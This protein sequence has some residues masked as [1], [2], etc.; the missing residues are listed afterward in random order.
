VTLN[1]LVTGATGNI[2]TW[3]APALSSMADIA[4]RGFVRDAAK[5]QPLVDAGVEVAVGDFGDADSLRRA[6]SGIDTVILIAPPGPRC[7]DQNHNIVAAAADAGVGKIVRISA[8]KA[9]PDGRTENTRLHGQCDRMLQA[10]GL[11]FVIL[12]PN[13]F[14]QNI[15]LSLDSIKSEHRFYAGMGGGRFAMIDVRDVADAALAAAT[16]SDFDGEI[17]ELSGPASISFHDVASA[18]GEV[19]G[20]DI[21]YIA[22]SPEQVEASLLELGFDPWMAGLLREYS[23]AYGEDWGDL[24]TDNV[25]RLTGH[26]PRGIAAFA[27]ELLGPALARG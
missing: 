13:Y 18:L 11:D 15:F 16:T 26:P 2:G 17:L 27:C 14:M 5:G 9:A 22:I 7:V 20:R 10:S 19:A 3:L 21:S 23:A 6:A 8:I 25:A 4:V 12:R 24:V 1:I